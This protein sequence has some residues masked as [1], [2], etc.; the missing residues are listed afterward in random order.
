MSDP[1]LGEIRMF[2]FAYAPLYWAQCDGAVMQ[3]NQNQALY[4]LLNIQ[5]GSSS[6]TTFNLPD[7]RGRTPMHRDYR[8]PTYQTGK[9]GGAETV[10][11]TTNQIPAHTHTLIATTAN[12]TTNFPDGSCLATVATAGQNLY[13]DASNT[14]LGTMGSGTIQNAGGSAAHNNMQPFGVIN[15]CIA[16]QG[17]YPM[18]D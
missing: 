7:L 18:R 3:V 5:F 8:S 4:S 10:T 6:S 14:P 12:A 11:I 13:A 1:F 2:T 17:I 16:T 9:S 15:F